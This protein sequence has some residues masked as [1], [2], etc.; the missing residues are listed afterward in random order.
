MFPIAIWL[1]TVK[2]GGESKASEDVPASYAYQTTDNGKTFERLGG[3]DVPDRRFDEHMILELADGRLMMLVRT[4]YGI[5]VTY[6]ADKGKTWGA[7]EDSGLGGP[8]SRFFIRRL[9][10]GRILLVNHVEFTGR[11]NL[12]A[13]L[14]EDDG[15]TWKYKLLLDERSG[16]SYP[17]GVEAEDGYIYIT[18]D[19]GRGGFKKTMEQ[20]LSSAREVLFARF[21]E[22]DVIAGEIVSEKGALK[23]IIS[24]LGEYKGE[25]LFE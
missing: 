12:T 2:W 25:P 22:E 21:T 3:A 19:R 7:G 10:S 17:D 9:K 23:Q 16:V 14:S 5:G 8:C 24:K 1:D 11:N 20:A 18:Y 6:S 15:M 4:N 13:L